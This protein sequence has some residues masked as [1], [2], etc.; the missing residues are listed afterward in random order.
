MPP[1]SVTPG[2]SGVSKE[3]IM[4]RA[5]TTLAGVT[6]VVGLAAPAWADTAQKPADRPITAFRGGGGRGG[7]GRGGYGRG[8]YGRGGYGRGGYGRGGYGRY[9]YG[10]YGR[11]DRYGYGYGYGG[12]DGYYY[13]R[14]DDGCGYGY[15]Y[16]YDGCNDPY[17]YGYGYRSYDAPAPSAQSTSTAPGPSR[18]YRDSGSEETPTRFGSTSDDPPGEGRSHYDKLH[19]NDDNHDD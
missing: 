15:G 7:Y 11:G 14:Y 12:Y 8:G 5:L 4:R 17:G 3:V 16:G 18:G 19:H 1:L 10:R 13:D 9:G 6:L 2:R